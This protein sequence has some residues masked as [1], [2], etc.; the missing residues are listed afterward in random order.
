MVFDQIFFLHSIISSKISHHP[1][2][3]LEPHKIRIVLEYRNSPS[4]AQALEPSFVFRC[5][6]DMYV[7]LF[8]KLTNIS[9]LRSSFDDD[10]DK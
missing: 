1:D 9:I 3:L 2:I 6:N 4:L 8:A 5:D 10:I 7:Y